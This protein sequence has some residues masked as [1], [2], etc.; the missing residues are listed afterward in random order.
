MMNSISI[1]WTWFVGF[2]PK[3]LV[4]AIVVVA[5]IIIN[6]FLPKLITKIY[7]KAT[8]D[9]AALNYFKTTA[10][11]IVWVF[12]IL[13]ILEKFGFPMASLLTVI[14]AVGAAFALAIKDSLANLASGLVLLFTK[15]FKA[16][17]LIEVDGFL[18]TVTDVQLIH[19]F[20]DTVDNSHVAIPN[21]KMMSASVSNISGNGTRRQ[22]VVFSI[23]YDQDID[24]AKNV[25]E[26]VAAADSRIMKSPAPFVAVTNHDDSA[27]KI[28]LRVWTTHADYWDVQYA[29][30]ENVKK[31]FDAN[32]IVI[33]F[34]Q[35]DVHMV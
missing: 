35:M 6:Q 20:I 33:P 28:M 32:G 1:A 30:Y 15:P 12:A 31:A 3:L 14:A 19:T 9:D 17:D 34:P 4:C 27:V 5:A 18:G 22:D 21:S 7:H 25:L 23:A 13:I 8:D 11:I 10:K 29:L 24:K 26:T 16:G 2:L